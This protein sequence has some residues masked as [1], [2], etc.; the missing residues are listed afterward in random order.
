[1]RAMVILDESDAMGLTYTTKR[2]AMDSMVEEINSTGGLGGS[3]RPVEL[4]YCVTQFDPNLAQQCARDAVDDDS[5]VAV[6]GMITNYPDQVNP[7]LE[8]AGMASVGTEPY[9][10][11]D[12]TSPIAFPITAG[13]LSSVAGMGTVLADVAGSTKISVIHVDVP[14]A[15]ASVGTIETAL[16]PRGL[17]L[18][19]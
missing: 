2:A 16:A 17:D 5:I 19:K 14:S 9:G 12:G 10:Y 6:V 8:E 3:G 11:A 13:F 18:V 15:Q 1:V 7:I 4:E